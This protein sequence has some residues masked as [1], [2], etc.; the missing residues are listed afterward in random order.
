MNKYR[1]WQRLFWAF[2][3]FVATS[4]AGGAQDS[5]PLPPSGKD[6]L[7]SVET[8][9]ETHKKKEKKLQREVK[10]IARDLET[11]KKKLVTLARSIQASEE[12]LALLNTKIKAMEK[13]QATIQKTLEEDRSS[14]AKLILALE[15]IRRVPPQALMAK[16][17]APYKTA[18]SAMLM[19]D[20]VPA[21]NKQ[22]ESL[23]KNLE[24]LNIL[25]EELKT[26]H[27]RALRASQSL[28]EEQQKLSNLVSQKERLYR[29]GNDDLVM[30]RENIAKISAQAKT[31]KELLKKLEDEKQKNIESAKD[32]SRPAPALANFTPGAARLP[33][34]GIVRLGYNQPDSFGAPSQ[35]IEIES[36]GGALIVAPMEGIVRFAGVFKNYG[37]MIILEHAGGYHSL[38]GGLEKLDAAV[39]EHIN[40]GEP[41]GLLHHSSNNQKPVLY[42]ELRLDGVA[43]DPAKKFTDLG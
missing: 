30:Q 9:L 22:A 14:I 21:L 32:R 18:Q 40:T 39:G 29:E 37:Q 17:D 8:I 31:L 6:R 27:A 12:E 13:K 26:D 43:I 16:P 5:A 25:S 3:V 19:S 38:I 11:T 10:T 23:R 35:G 41:I 33:V 2:V 42:Y 7:G 24:T 34:S 15:R 4:G 36:Q 1:L 20:I 28:R